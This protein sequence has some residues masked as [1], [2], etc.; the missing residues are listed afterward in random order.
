MDDLQGQD[1]PPPGHQTAGRSLCECSWRGAVVAGHATHT[2]AWQVNYPRTRFRPATPAP[3]FIVCSRDTLSSMLFAWRLAV[4]PLRQQRQQ[5]GGTAG[6]SATTAHAFP[7]ASSLCFMLQLPQVQMLL[8]SAFRCVGKARMA[9]LAM[10]VWE[11]SRNAHVWG[12]GG[13]GG[14]G[15][16]RSRAGSAQCRNSLCVLE[17]FSLLPQS[18]KQVLLAE[19]PLGCRCSR[20]IA[21]LKVPLLMLR[22]AAICLLFR[23]PSR[24]L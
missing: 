13:S 6:S 7:C 21:R 11:A 2:A 16:G 17:R 12:G 23:H 15:G 10:A 5:Q 3:P 19:L 9:A 24:T 8:N 22:F 20:A 18:H 14:G 4:L 1:R